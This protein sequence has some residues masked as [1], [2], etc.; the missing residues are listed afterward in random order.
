MQFRKDEAK[1]KIREK[2]ER[3]AGLMDLWVDGLLQG[4]DGADAVGKKGKSEYQ[5]SGPGALRKTQFR[6]R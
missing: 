4:H 1:A 3:I 5:K 6:C 2:A